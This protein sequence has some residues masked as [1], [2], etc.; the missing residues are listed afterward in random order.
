M[1]LIEPCLVKKE[2][3]IWIIL[4]V[5]SEKNHRN[6]LLFPKAGYCQQK[7]IE[8]AKAF[9]LFLKLSASWI[10]PMHS[11]SPPPLPHTLSKGNPSLPTPYT[12]WVNSTRFLIT[13]MGWWRGWGG[14]VAEIGLRRWKSPSLGAGEEGGWD[15]QTKQMPLALDKFGDAAE[16]LCT[17]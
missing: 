17:I 14:G 10:Q 5:N 15:T 16:K 1:W 3:R 2:S 8:L 12:S 7:M 11:I 9:P 13:C 6:A 4:K